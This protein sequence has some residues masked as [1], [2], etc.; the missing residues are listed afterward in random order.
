[1]HP[2]SAEIRPYHQDQL[3]FLHQ[4]RLHLGMLAFVVAAV[5]EAW[6]FALKTNLSKLMFYGYKIIYKS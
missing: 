2:F 3:P 6:A 1:M 5:V 4:K